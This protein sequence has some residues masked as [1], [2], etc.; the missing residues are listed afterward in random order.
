LLNGECKGKMY[1]ILLNDS[2]LKYLRPDL[3]E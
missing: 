2:G 3:W 1:V